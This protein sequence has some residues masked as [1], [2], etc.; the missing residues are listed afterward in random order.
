ME[1]LTAWFLVLTVCVSQTD[2]AD[3]LAPGAPYYTQ[4]DCWLGG[5]QQ[6]AERMRVEGFERVEVSCVEL[7]L[8]RN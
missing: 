7:P 2:C 5:L 8:E 3:Q 1:G 4:T 6:A